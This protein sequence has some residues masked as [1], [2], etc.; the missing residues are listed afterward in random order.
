MPLN[1]PNT[2]E[3][4]D[5]FESYVYNSAVGVWNKATSE[6][7]VSSVTVSSTP[8]ENPDVGDTWFDSA[9][10]KTYIRYDFAWVEIATNLVGPV[11]PAGSTGPRGIQGADGPTGPSGPAGPTNSLSVGTVTTG[12]T[13]E[14]AEATITGTAPSQT[15]N[16]TLPRG[17]QGI[18][19]L[20]GPKG[21]T[22]S[23]NYDIT[24]QGSDGY[25]INGA[26][27][28]TI[29]VIRG[30]PYNFNINATNHPLYIQTIGGGYSAGSVYSDGVVGNGTQV[31]TITWLVPFDAPNTL[32]YQCQYHV[33]MYGAI[34]VYD[35]GPSNTISI[36][37]V[38]GG[39]TAGATLTGSSPNQT[40]NLVLPQGEP[41][42][43]GQT[44]VVSATAPLSYNLESR[45]MSLDTNTLFTSPTLTGTPSA[46]TATPGTNTTQISTTA[47]VESKGTA[48]TTSIT[49]S[50]VDGAPTDLNTLNKIAAAIDDDPTYHTTVSN[51]LDLKADIS[52]TD[53]ITAPNY[54]IGVTSNTG[55]ILLD[56]PALQVNL[57]F[58]AGTGLLSAT[59]GALDDV[60]S[61]SFSGTGYVAGAVKT[62]RIVNQSTDD[63]NIDFFPNWKVVGAPQT[64]MPPEKTAI[65]TVTSF[66]TSA[67]DCVAAWVMEV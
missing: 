65:I 63:I 13:G 41:G 26:L 27:N 61:I 16:L 37:T 58:S 49:S 67:E 2:P 5:V 1:F 28:P 23:I 57:N 18:Q 59:I 12:A 53:I 9:S 7:D 31:G 10:G 44:G 47:F 15:L 52:G 34:E 3:D 51:A 30:M 56:P 29:R 17:A 55:E 60:S 40:L 14:N 43:Q 4:G 39:E 42:D 19:G 50:I 32:Y 38:I 35:V 33:N 24:A 25:L 20:I 8:P 64:F 22:G 62:I 6:G 11:G 66:G 45:S 46:P 36:G 21:D 54:N 48:L